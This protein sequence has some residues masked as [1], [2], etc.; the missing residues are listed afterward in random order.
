LPNPGIWKRLFKFGALGTKKKKNI[1]KGGKTVY[2]YIQKKGGMNPNKEKLRYDKK[3]KQNIAFKFGKSDFF[4]KNI[5]GL[6]FA[7]LGIGNGKD[8]F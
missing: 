2:F 3:E 4:K 6:C 1:Y 7:T 5:Q 8:V